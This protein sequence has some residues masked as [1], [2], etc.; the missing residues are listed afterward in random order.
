MVKVD[1]KEDVKKRVHMAKK[2]LEKIKNKKIPLL[3]FVIFGSTARNRVK[4]LSDIDILIIVDKKTKEIWDILLEEA[5]KIEKINEPNF[6]FILKT[7]YN[8]KEDPLILLDMTEESIVLHDPDGIF[9]NLIEKLRK[10]LKELGSKRVWIDEDTWYWDLKP[11]W[12][13]GEVVEIKL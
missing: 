7:P 1:M 5:R 4:E 6:S 10:K 13:P 11:D 2:L 12:K 3:S 9:R 8:L